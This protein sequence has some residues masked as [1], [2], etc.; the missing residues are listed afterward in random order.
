MPDFAPG[1]LLMGPCTAYY[2]LNGIDTVEPLDASINSAPA[3]S[4][5]DNMGLTLGGVNT[6]VTPTY[7]PLLADQIPEE[8]GARLTSRVISVAIPL[9]EVTLKNIARG[10][11]G[12]YAGTPETGESFELTTGPSAFAQ[13]YTKLILDGF[14]PDA[15]GAERRRRI[16]LRKILQ[17]GNTELMQSKDGQQVLAYVFNCYYLN[18][19]T[20]PIRVFDAP[21]AA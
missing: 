15:T 9:A 20:S 19:T 10:N 16:T 14:A 21:L 2:G 18:S 8:V 13:T 6:T 12:T 3:A 5:W 4:A 17:A 7:S 11:K 1:N